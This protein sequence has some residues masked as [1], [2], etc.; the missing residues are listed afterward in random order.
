VHVL[1][2]KAYADAIRLGLATENP[3]ELADPPSVRASRPHVRSPWSAAELGHFLR[4]ARSDRFFAAYFLAAATGM[5][6]GEVLG[7]RWTDIDFE[8]RQLRV[9]QTIVEAGH[10]TMISEPKSDRSRRVIAL[11]NRTLEVLAEHH[12][13]DFKHRSD[14]FDRVEAL[15]FAHGDGEPIHPACFSYAFKH[16]IKLTG[17][18]HVRFHDLRH[19][20]ATMALH[21]GIHPKVVAERLGHSTVAITLDVY[22]HAIPSMQ[23]EAAEA[24][25]ALISL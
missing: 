3:A 10:K 17:S 25:A 23:R 15:V 1:L 6:R 12:R 14:R 4:S 8:E 21:A 24:V 2:R 19:G 11:D 5:R 20:H 22:S 13:E 16:R 7:L 18:R 9:V